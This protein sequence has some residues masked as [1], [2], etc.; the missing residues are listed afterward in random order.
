MIFISKYRNN[1]FYEVNNPILYEM[2]DKWK[3]VISYNKLY[4]LGELLENIKSHLFT[5]MCKLIADL[6]SIAWSIRLGN[7]Y[8]VTLFI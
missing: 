8:F 3:F 2:I 6:L 7:M 4:L 5:V 1:T